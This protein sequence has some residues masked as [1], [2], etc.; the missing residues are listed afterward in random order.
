MKTIDKIELTNMNGDTTVAFSVKYN[1]AFLFYQ[2]FD[3]IMDD[4][5]TQIKQYIKQGWPEQGGG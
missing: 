2:T 5:A 1:F 4:D 3:L